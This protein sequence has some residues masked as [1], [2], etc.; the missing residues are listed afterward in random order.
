MSSVIFT[1]NDDGWR[2]LKLSKRV[3]SRTNL[4]ITQSHFGNGITITTPSGQDEPTPMWLL[5]S[6]AR[7]M[8]DRT[9][10]CVLI[11]CGCEIA[12]EPDDCSA[13]LE[14]ETGEFLR[15][16]KLGMFP[17]N[18]MSFPAT[19]DAYRVTLNRRINAVYEVDIEPIE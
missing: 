19:S 7:A 8:G 13:T 11:T 17:A 9:N 1:F 10:M 12:N 15:H 14:F 16:F 3:T 6:L 18:Q 2:P 5:V 4:H